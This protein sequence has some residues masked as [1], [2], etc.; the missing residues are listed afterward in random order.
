MKTAT[1]KMLTKSSLPVRKSTGRALCIRTILVPTDFSGPSLKAMEYARLLAKTFRASVHLINV[2][3]VQFEAPALAPL[4]A[5]DTQ[6]ERRLRQRLHDIATG[7]A[8]P[9]RA[10]RCHARIGR[11]FEEICQAARKLRANLIVTA[12]HGHTGLK[13]VLIGSTAERIVR[14]APCPVLVV[15]EKGRQFWRKKGGAAAGSQLRIKNILVPVDFSEHSRTALCFAIALAQR[16]GAKLTLLNVIY[17]HYYAT[18]AD[19]LAYD[20]A[21]LLNETRKATKYDIA[22]LVRKTAFQGVPFTAH[23]TEGHPGLSIVDYAKRHGVDLIVN[24]THGRTGLAHVLLGSTAEHIVRYA[25]CPVL[26]VPT[27]PKQT[28]K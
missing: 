16:F 8:E 23:V 19:F 3:D 20:Y 11:A 17:L 26:V 14:H 2:F 13:H 21:L 15:R 4:Y 22:E 1:R 18:N 6:V 27:K 5:T 24:A 28:R 25:Q 7:L 10:A 9:I 12:T